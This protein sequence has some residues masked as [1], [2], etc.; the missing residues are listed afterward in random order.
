MKTAAANA[1]QTRSLPTFPAPARQFAHDLS[2]DWQAWSPWERYAARML[3]VSSLL[4]GAFYLG[5][6]VAASV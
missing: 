4:L 6:L 5:L 1:S 3:A 2:R